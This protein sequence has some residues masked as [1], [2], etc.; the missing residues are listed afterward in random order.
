MLNPAGFRTTNARRITP[1]RHINSFPEEAL[2]RT[3]S[4]NS[5]DG[6]GSDTSND[7]AHEEKEGR[8]KRKKKP[9]AWYDAKDWILQAVT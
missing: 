2:R 8:P 5:Q 3:L 4:V 9:S 6:P 7:E 1:S